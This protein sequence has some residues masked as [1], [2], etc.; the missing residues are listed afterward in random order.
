MWQF[1]HILVV[2]KFKKPNYTEPTRSVHNT[3]DAFS[4][5]QFISIFMYE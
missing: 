3:A 2:K 1:Y 5:F 4:E